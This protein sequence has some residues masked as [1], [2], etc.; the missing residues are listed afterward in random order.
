MS[1][2][3]QGRSLEHFPVQLF[4][5]IMGVSGLTIMFAKASHI[6]DA[7]IWIYYALLAID[8][9]LFFVIF[10]TYLM[11]WLLYPEAVYKE[12][13]HPIKSSF[14]ATISISLLLLSIAYYDFAPPVALAFWYIGAPLQLAFTLL[15]MRFWILGE[16]KIVHSN[17]AW[18]IPIVGN[19]LVPIVGV[20]AAPLGV[21]LLFFAVGVFFWIVLST[22]LI[23]RIVFHHP[24]PGKLLPTFFI[25]IAP[26]A[27]AFVSYFRISMGNIDLFSASLYFIALFFLFF[28]IF[29]TKMFSFRQFFISWWAYTFPMAAITIATLLLHMVLRLPSTYWGSIILM[30]MTIVIVGYVTFKTIIACKRQEICVAEIE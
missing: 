4:A 13:R 1:D 9:I 16:F 24:M 23:Y 29:L 26:P 22:I 28:L 6:I 14:M 30:A 2:G 8:T 19:V 15:V 20:E 21:S 5:I 3:Q 11:K 10:T 12:F 27:V 25:F 18:F 17:P 7:P